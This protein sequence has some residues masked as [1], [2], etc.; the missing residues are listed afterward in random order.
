MHYATDD[1]GKDGSVHL[2][3]GWLWSGPGPRIEPLQPGSH[4]TPEFSLIALRLGATTALAAAAVLLA[5]TRWKNAV[6]RN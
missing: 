6:T 2:G 4:T 1:S 3:Y 5:G